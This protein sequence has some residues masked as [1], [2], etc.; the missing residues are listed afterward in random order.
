MLAE[1]SDV[2]R[3][4]QPVQQVQK[5]VRG[6]IG[7]LGRS[8]FKRRSFNRIEENI[9]EIEFDCDDGKSMQLI[10]FDRRNRKFMVI[11]ETIEVEESDCLA[12]FWAEWGR[13]DLVFIDFWDL[14]RFW[15]INFFWI[16]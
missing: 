6:V 11:E 9:N 7:L 12:F 16:F 2:Q 4:P 15:E 14:C 1:A 3:R 10:Q 5:H 13:F 8:D